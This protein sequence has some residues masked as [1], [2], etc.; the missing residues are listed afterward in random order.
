MP[1]RTLSI[2]V[3]IALL[4]I[5]LSAVVPVQAQADGKWAL[6]QGLTVKDTGPRTYK[7][8]VDYNSGNSKGE[9]FQRQRLTG[10]TLVGCPVEMLC[11]R[12]SL[13]P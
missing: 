12:T 8:V 7:F 4:F 10:N 6:P 1:L 13:T 2:L 5:A 3:R 11:G 9:I